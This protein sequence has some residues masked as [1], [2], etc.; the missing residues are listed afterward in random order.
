MAIQPPAMSNS[1]PTSPLEHHY[2]LDDLTQ[3]CQRLSA[4]LLPD[5]WDPEMPAVRIERQPSGMIGGIAQ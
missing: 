5:G 3:N 4:R 2:M 1:R